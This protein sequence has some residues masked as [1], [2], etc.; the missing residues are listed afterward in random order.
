VWDSTRSATAIAFTP[1]PVLAPSI[2]HALDARAIASTLSAPPIAPAIAKP[3][4]ADRPAVVTAPE[5]AVPVHSIE[6]R[7]SPSVATPP[8]P[9]I[10]TSSSA[11]TS[12]WSTDSVPIDRLPLDQLLATARGQLASSAFAGALATADLAAKRAPWSSAWWQLVG[13]AQRGLGHAGAAA[14]A[15]EHVTGPERGEAGYTAA[16]L[17]HHDLHD[18]TK[19]L[20]SLDASGAAN[21]GA[22]LEERGL[23]LRAQILVS[24]GRRPDAA[25]VARRYL[26]RFPRADLRAYMA[27]L[28][29]SASARPLR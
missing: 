3:V 9:S 18:D 13:D 1:S 8:A 12:P 7:V 24:L 6:S 5:H 11:S 25:D 17:R 16:Y 2:A 22:P 21:P 26:A 15:F 19:A 23:G 27:G 4:V 10:A 28:V 29:T 20:A 14:T